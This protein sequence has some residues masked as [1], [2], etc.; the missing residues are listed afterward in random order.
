MTASILMV[1]VIVGG[2]AALFI[3]AR[4][5]ALRQFRDSDA[6]SEA[7]AFVCP[8]CDT[9]SVRP[10]AFDTACSIC[11]YAPRRVYSGVLK[12]RIQLYFDAAYAADH[13]R[14]ASANLSGSD[15]NWEE[16]AF[17]ISEGLSLLDGG[18]PLAAALR[19]IDEIDVAMQVEAMVNDNTDYSSL[20]TRY[21]SLMSEARAA[22]RV[23]IRRRL[24]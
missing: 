11:G 12:S 21:E 17:E 23:D 13:F 22:L 20:A 4:L 1:A 7:S 15:Y 18:K 9:S 5:R 2:V 3:R 16:Y 6:A 10:D 8:I 24:S 19:E 14:E